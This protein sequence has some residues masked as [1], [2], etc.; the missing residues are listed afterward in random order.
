LSLVARTLREG[1]RILQDTLLAGRLAKKKGLLQSLNPKVKIIST[2]FL[3]FTVIFTNNLLVALLMCAVLYI[4]AFSSRIPLGFYV[5]RSWFFIP[6]FSV[7][8][9]FPSL[10]IYGETP[11]LSLNLFGF[12]LCV[13][14]EGLLRMLVFVF[15]VYLSVSALLLLIYTTELSRI[16]VSLCSFGV[17]KSLLFMVALTYRYLFLF[18]DELY[19]ILIGW[20]SRTVARLSLN[21]LWS[22]GAMSVGALLIRAY[23]RGER[24][25]MAMKA[26][27]YDGQ[28]RFPNTEKLKLRDYVYLMTI[29]AF[30]V[31]LIFLFWS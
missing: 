24:I 2:F 28:I 26:R 29:S 17:P 27:G 13:F 23:E 20:E 11:L 6:L 14:R 3:I 12:H 5:R 18:L 7:F 1:G 25:Y 31:A 15:R 16:L 19:G 10:F 30:L 4:L 21:K 22:G 9:A 8:V